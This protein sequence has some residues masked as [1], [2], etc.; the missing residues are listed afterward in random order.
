MSSESQQRCTLSTRQCQSPLAH[1]SARRSRRGIRDKLVGER[2]RADLLHSVLVPSRLCGCDQQ[3]E[4]HCLELG[5]F[6]ENPT[7]RLV[8]LLLAEIQPDGALLSRLAS[9]LSATERA[10]LVGAG[11]AL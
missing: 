7:L 9:P 11:L 1:L 3:A 10:A 6:L 4:A 8:P 2:L 5:P